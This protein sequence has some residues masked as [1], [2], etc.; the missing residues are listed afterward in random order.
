M[1][2]SIRHNADNFWQAYKSMLKYLSENAQLKNQC[3]LIQ[4][5]NSNR[6]IMYVMAVFISILSSQIL[7]FC[8]NTNLLSQ[9]G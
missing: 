5:H 6:T 3:A 8:N 4:S 2:G 1:C 7:L 9:G